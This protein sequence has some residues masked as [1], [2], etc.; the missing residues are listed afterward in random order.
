M[1]KDDAHWRLVTTS[2]R[3]SPDEIVS[4][5]FSTSFRGLAEG[6]VRAWLKRVAADVAGLRERERELLEQV[7]DLRRQSTEPVEVT[8]ERLLAALGEETARVLRAAQGAAED[9]RRKA[10]ERVARLVHDAQEEARR[11]R[12]EAEGILETRTGEADATADELL[13]EAG[14]FA[15]R[16]RS[17]AETHAAELRARV[18][19]EAVERAEAA[20]AAGREIVE[21]AQAVRERVLSD[22]ATRRAL[23]QT[24][25]EELRGGRDRL[26]DAYRTVKRTLDEATDALAQVESRASSELP[27]VPLPPLTDIDALLASFA[28]VD[29]VAASLAE[30]IT[31]SEPPD[32]EL[33]ENREVEVVETVASRPEIEPE[34]EAP[35]SA[36]ELPVPDMGAEGSSPSEVEA[37]FARLRGAAVS[38][39]A[40]VGEPVAV[41]DDV[42]A[43]ADSEVEPEVEEVDPGD[44]EGE[45]G[46]DEGD[47]EVEEGFLQRRDQVLDPLAAGLLRK[48]KRSMQDEQ[49]GVLDSLRRHR[50][51]MA[52]LDAEG[53]FPS[54][55][56]Q[57]KTCTDMVASVLAQSYEA[58]HGMSRAKH[59]GDT[60]V[61]QEMAELLAQALVVPLRERVVAGASEAVTLGEEQSGIAER[62]NA[63]YREWKARL[64]EPVIRDAL[65]A[66]FTRGLYDGFA[67]GTMLRWIVDDDAACPDCD[68]NALDVTERG[69]LFP[70]G[71]AF[72]PAHPGCRCTIAAA[73]ESAATPVDVNA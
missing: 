48:L 12:E 30:E 54:Q 5:A 9:I 8:E 40:E 42:V 36:A 67:P 25:L 41:D 4:R 71:Q 15:A 6:E 70:T 20:R 7:S 45:P 32:P 13:R 51:P 73:L 44:S 35:K 65:A 56:D 3:I 37:L 59:D 2:G 64:V 62:I 33:P 49:N 43:E 17:D 28:Q 72:P 63:R 57:L 29:A 58:G 18:G 66:A 27:G 16:V 21:E 53:L 31:A 1:T 23:L 24:Q 26:L 22:L 60:S 47:P 14:E 39:P 68:D 38:E 55:E 50:G 46:V 19:Q 61:S 34:V 10:E 52:S 69:S 11:I